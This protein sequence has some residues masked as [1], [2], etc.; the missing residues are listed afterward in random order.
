MTPRRIA[1]LDV[2][3]TTLRAATFDA[4]TRSL[5]AVTRMPTA[6]LGLGQTAPPD[7]LQRNVVEQL[8]QAAQHQ[9]DAGAD[10]ALLAF[11]GPVTAD[12][13]VLAA[14]TV[15]GRGWQPVNLAELAAS[16]LDVPVTVVNE[17]TAATWRYRAPA[18]DPFC[19]VTVSSGIGN[20][21]LW[22][23]QV[24]VGPSGSG[25]EI[26]HWQVDPSPAAAPCDCGG[27]G[28]LGGIASGRGAEAA[29]RAAAAA[30]PDRFAASALAETATPDTV[31]TRDLV[32]AVHAGDA[33]ALEVLRGGTGALARALTAMF[34]AIGVRRF[35]VIGGFAQAVGP[36]YLAELRQ[37]LADASCFLM[38]RDEIDAMVEFGASDDVHSLVG[39][40]LWAL[41]HPA[42]AQP[43]R[44]ARSA[45]MRVAR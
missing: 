43:A 9:V 11:A 7:V 30:D 40:G 3:G 15:V 16:R 28:H 33:L 4:A 25:G 32:R 13:T 37:A 6:G 18:G 29:V 21:V 35:V 1:V 12:G 19:L 27:R 24:L 5:G 45:Q 38:R 23:D 22:G 20:K 2:G 26:G 36:P 34:T 39:G 41:D 8:L 10:A 44:S 17:L 14:P 42:T 31:S